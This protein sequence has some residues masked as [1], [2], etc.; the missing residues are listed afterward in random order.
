MSELVFYGVLFL[1]VIVFVIVRSRSK[2]KKSIN[3][4]VPSA[5]QNTMSAGAD[6]QITAAISAAVSEYRKTR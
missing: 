2:Q 6:A 1:L 4:T 3:D 5:S